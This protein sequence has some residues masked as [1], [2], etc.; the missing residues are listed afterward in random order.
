M[1]LKLTDLCF[2]SE[3]DGSSVGYIIYGSLPDVRIQTSLDGINWSDWDGSDITL[4][5]DEKLYVRNLANTLNK[6]KNR[7]EFRMDGKIAASGNVNS[8]INYSG[9]SDYCYL[10]LFYMCDALTTAPILPAMSLVNRCYEY[11]FKSCESLV[12]APFLPATTLVTGCYYGMFEGCNKLNYLKVGFGVPGETTWPEG[13]CTKN[14][15]NK[16]V[17]NTGT[18]V[19]KGSTEVTSRGV[20]TIPENWTIET[21]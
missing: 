15:F 3:K 18:F 12:I 1:E 21:Y 20:N 5:K 17:A 13:D 14:W 9:L 11:M 7:L 2:T 8:M 10:Y 19:W 6:P 4:N 16:G